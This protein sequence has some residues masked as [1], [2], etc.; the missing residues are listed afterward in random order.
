MYKLLVVDDEPTVRYGLRNYMNWEKYGIKFSAEADDGDT[1]LEAVEQFMPDIVLT[2]VRMPNMDG[3]TLSK[4]IRRRYPHM[5]IVFISGHDDA[6]YMK[7]A[8]KVSAVDYI[9]KPVNLQELCLVIER[10]VADL[11][12]ESTERRMMQ[13]MQVK[14]KESMPL[15]REKFLMSLISDKVSQPERIRE[16]MDFLGLQ[17]PRAVSFWVVV[18]SVDNL[19]DIRE[20]RSEQD[21]QL[22]CYAVQNVCQELADQ[23]LNGFIFE[24]RGEFVGILYADTDKVSVAEHNHGM[25]E[26]DTSEERL[27]L[28]ASDIRENLK[29]LLKIGV[30][31]GIGERVSDLTGLSQSYVQ[32]SEAVARKWY[33]GKNRIIT[34]DSLESSNESYYTFDYAQSSEFVSI[35]KGAD[36]SQLHA[37][38][39]DLFAKLSLNRRDGLKYC[40]NAAMQM[41]LMAKQLLLELN[42]QVNE[43]E[44]EEALH[45]ERLFKLETADEL[46][47][48]LES[49]LVYVCHKIN[50][51][52]SGR[53]NNL[54]GRV[55]AIIERRYS[56][57]ALTVSEIGKEVYLTDTYVSLLFKQETGKTVNEY[58]THY[59]IERAKELLK[60]PS[61]K[62]YDICF[63]VGYADPSYF[64]KLFKKATGLTPS[65][66]R[67]IL[68]SGK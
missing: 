6:E 50:E 39:G 26:I 60:D 14:L 37:S 40:R 51:R 68:H 19:A 28:L 11:N 44:D 22:L 8:M 18:I 57:N 21:W 23:Y 52:R 64:S 7:S 25:S 20:T 30:T 54:V 13:D 38:L 42:L 53:A 4:E 17:I 56:D 46:R 32:A 49:K 29:L 1:A 3:I 55:H 63:A 67:D 47:H 2:D 5:K 48:F 61:Q 66:Y 15:L 31:I 45:V 34:M 65:A 16:R 62:L 41:M 33:L 10:V 36:A 35:L 43:L 12:A 59:R 27:F 9:F 24:Y 58:L